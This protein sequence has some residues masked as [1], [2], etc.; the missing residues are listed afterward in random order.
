[1]Y[2]QKENDNVKKCKSQNFCILFY[3]ITVL[4]AW[5]G[6]GLINDAYAPVEGRQRRRRIII[7][8]TNESFFSFNGCSSKS[9]K[10]CQIQAV[11]IVYPSVFLSSD[12]LDAAIVIGMIMMI[13]AASKKGGVRVRRIMAILGLV[14]VAI[15]FSVILSIFRSKAHGY[16]YRYDSPFFTLHQSSYL[17]FAVIYS[18]LVES[19]QYIRR[20]LN[21]G[22][23]FPDS[24]PF[25]PMYAC[26]L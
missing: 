22:S 23:F 4:L 24:L 11:F 25:V 6:N 5:Q 10:C 9:W 26:Q 16:P 3:F 15:D 13:D 18:L 21:F 7:L 14:F 20:G 2:L 17:I 12:F 8:S 1:M 19:S